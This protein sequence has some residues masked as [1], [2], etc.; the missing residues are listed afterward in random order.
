[1]SP[2][3]LWP[4]EDVAALNAFYGDPRGPN[5]KANPAWEAK[6]LVKW[7]LPYPM[8]YSWDLHTPVDHIEVHG[9]CR[10]TFDAA[11]KAVLA[12]LGPDYIG[13]HRLNITGGL[14]NFRTERGGSRLSVH[15]WWCAMD[16]DPQ[17]NNYPSHWAPNKGM[18][19]EKFTAILKRFGFCWR[20]DAAHRDIDPMHFQLCRH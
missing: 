6:N 11:F 1:M 2:Q 20:G 4:H 15:S 7:L 18:I 14:G 9:K 5:G 13:A 19:D 10:D 8:F 3:S 16:M 12:E 17:H